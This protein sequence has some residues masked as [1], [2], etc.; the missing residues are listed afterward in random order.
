M[1]NPPRAS[2]SLQK[3]E[4][5]CFQGYKHAFKQNQ[6]SI[7]S[8]LRE[9]FEVAK[10]CFFVKISSLKSRKVSIC[11]QRVA[12]KVTKDEPSVLNYQKKC[13]KELFMMRLKV[14][15]AKYHR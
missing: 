3:H 11:K 13:F 12:K 15:S 7:A 8:K 2:G 5:I 10:R 14:F 6:L 1:Q 9:E 4:N